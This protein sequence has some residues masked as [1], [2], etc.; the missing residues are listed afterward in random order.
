MAN[1]QIREIVIDGNIAYVPLTK[2]KVAI[3]DAEDIPLVEGWNWTA[4]KRND[5]ETFYAARNHYLGGGR[6]IRKDNKSGFKGVT[7]STAANKWAASITI[8][9]KRKHLGTFASAKEAHNAYCRAA[10]NAFG[11]FARFK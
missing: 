5:G 2:G 11:E 9:G 10:E 4:V 8:N 3:I 7:W 6:R 1:R